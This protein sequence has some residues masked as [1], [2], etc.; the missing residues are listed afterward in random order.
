MKEFLHCYKDLS[1]F[2]TEYFNEGI[3][4]EPWVSAVKDEHNPQNKYVTFNKGET[5]S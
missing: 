4:K 5:P 2:Q 3:Y 1:S